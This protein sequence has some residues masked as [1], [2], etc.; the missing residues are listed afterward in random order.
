MDPYPFKHP[1]V[2]LARIRKGIEPSLYAAGFKLDGRNKPRNPV[3]I[4]LDYSRPGELFR[5]SWDRRDSNH[6]ISFVAEL[7][8]GDESR[9]VAKTDLHSVLAHV[10]KHAI[11]AE[12]LMQIDRFVDAVNDFFGDTPGKGSAQ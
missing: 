4:Y 8:A 6:F 12:L 10:P 5:L 7:L 3:Y 9:V 1:A 2:I 11:T